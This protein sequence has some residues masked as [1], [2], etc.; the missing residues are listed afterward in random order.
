MAIETNDSGQT[1]SSQSRLA[2][3]LE[4][5]PDFVGIADSEGNLLFVNAAGR[6]M[7]GHEPT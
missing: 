2:A 1:Q 6:K 7:I 3:I 5:T 4:E